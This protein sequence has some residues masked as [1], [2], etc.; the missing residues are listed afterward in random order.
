VKEYDGAD[1]V[2]REA[3]VEETVFDGTAEGRGDG[4]FRR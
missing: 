3:V 4:T 1:D 2:D